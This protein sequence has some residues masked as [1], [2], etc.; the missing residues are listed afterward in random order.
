MVSK[1]LVAGLIGFS[2]IAAAGAQ[3]FTEFKVRDTKGK[4]WSKKALE[5][6]KVY[7][8]KFWATWCKSCKALE[9]M[10]ID[11]H[12]QYKPRGFEVLAVS[13][14]ADMG[15]LQRQ[16]TAEPKP[17][18]VLLDPR[19]AF[20]KSVKSKSVP[21]MILVKNGEV[22]GRW[23]GPVKREVLEKAIRGAVAK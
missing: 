10:V 12:K 13:V 20:L 6:N 5:P 1:V 15:A 22:V 16:L 11:L 18:P 23:V 14:D 2:L 9:P 17:F 21:T 7:L 3:S 4:E 8:F 19:S